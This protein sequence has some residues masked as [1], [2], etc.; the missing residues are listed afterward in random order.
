L[1]DSAVDAEHLDRA[2][3][4]IEVRPDFLGEDSLDAFLEF[5][6]SHEAPS[7]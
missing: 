4:E 2:A 6:G 5:S 7:I 1:N 3:V